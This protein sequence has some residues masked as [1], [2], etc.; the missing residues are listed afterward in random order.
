VS[1]PSYPKVYNLGHAAITDLFDGDVVVQEK[2]DGSQFSFGRVD[3]VLCMRSKGQEV[4]KEGQLVSSN[5]MFMPAIE[6]VGSI[7]D[8]IPDGF[9]FRAEF[10]AKPKHNTLAY[11]RVPVNNLMLFDVE[12]GE[13]NF[14]SHEFV[15]EWAHNLGIERVP[16]IKLRQYDVPT[17][18]KTIDFPSVLGGSKMEGLVFK[19]YTRFG[20][21]GKALMGKHVS[22]AFK[23]VH[24]G[25]WKERNP[26]GVDIVGILEASLRTPARWEKAV[27]HLME[28]GELQQAPQDIGPLMKEVTQDVLAEEAEYI[29]EQLFKWA[30]PKLA[31]GVGRGL[32]QWYKDKLMEAQFSEE[33]N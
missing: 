1:I 26:S 4:Y 13:A 23:E 22:E 8:R 9:V 20:R 29:K 21:D 16:Y 25:D 31:R 32:P 19:N 15:D 17:I 28:R 6:Y 3:G 11:D 30:W 7:A 27:Q 10:L 2:I 18:K 5:N 12:M 14:L 24:Q 33:G